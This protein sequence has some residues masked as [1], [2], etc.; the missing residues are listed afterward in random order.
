[1]DFEEYLVEL[2]KPATP[3]KASGLARLSDM[4]AEQARQLREVWPRLELQRRRKLL[5]QM[6]EL[7]EDNVDLNFD[8]VFLQA[9]E[10][11]EAEARLIAVRGLWEY[12]G[13]DATDPLLQLAERDESAKVRAEAALALGRFVLLSEHGRLRDRHFERVE[14]GLRRLFEDEQQTEDVRARALEAIGAHDSAWVRR[15]IGDAYESGVRRLKVSAVH[16]MGRSCEERWLPLVVKE[17]GSEDAEVRYEA[18]TAAGAIADES[19]VPYLAPLL[20]DEDIEVK[21][22]TITALGEIGGKQARD[23]L[24]ALADD[25]S[26]TVREAATEAL[27]EAEFAQDSLSFRDRI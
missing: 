21:Q 17:L 2:A 7:A 16:A 15:A 10:D 22:A 14:A 5:E 27:T 6:E 24:L 8:A 20:G 25:P 4:T 19:A 3:L 1:M 23:L 13:A 12:E 26:A 11:P 9:L 18:V